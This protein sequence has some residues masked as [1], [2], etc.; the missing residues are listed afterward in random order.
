[1][2]FFFLLAGS[3]AGRGIGIKAGKGRLHPMMNL[4]LVWDSNPG[5]QSSDVVSDLIIRV[6]PGLSL[7]LPS[8]SMDF[9]VDSRI[10]YDFFLGLDNSATRD[11]SSFNGDA[12]LM[13]AVNPNGPYGFTV[14][15]KFS[16]SSDPSYS[17]Y[18]QRLDR[19]NNGAKA[20]FH[21]K[22]GGGALSFDV[23]YGFFLDRFDDFSEMNN[24]GHRFYLT[25][26]WKFLP[27]TAVVVDCD[28]DLRR[29][30]ES[31]AGG[32]KNP[33]SNSIRA[34]LGLVGQIS[35]TI[36]VILKAGYGDSLLRGGTL[37]G[38]G[39]YT[40]DGYRSVI[41]QAEAS[42]QLGT[43]FIKG[44]Y[45]RSFMP[46]ASFGYFAQ[47]RLYAE[48]QKQL[49]GRFTLSAKLSFDIL[50]YGISVVE[51]PNSSGTDRTD[52]Y[53]DGSL[54]AEYHWIDWLAVGIRY[55]IRVL[56]SNWAEAEYTKHILTLQIHVDY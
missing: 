32:G 38:G 2:L 22:P 45:L 4:D 53:L 26:R 36:A 12:D 50:A 46:A 24:S 49:M 15:D 35:P 7:H 25:G 48:L 8:D 39:A 6:Q 11:W 52:H 47:D 51:T 30:P 3:A 34:T 17:G 23:G 33:D 16:R 13:L 14:T 40:G 31:S 42:Y 20:L 43:T 37:A 21:L 29:F 10:G 41:G 5:F 9:K 19:I 56:T 1:M 54:E 18:S 28:T 27:K 55:D 44:G